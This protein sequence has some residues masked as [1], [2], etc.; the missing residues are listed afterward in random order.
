MRRRSERGKDKKGERH[1]RTFDDCEACVDA[2]LER[3]GKRIVAGTPLG[4]G[5]PNALVNALYRR[6]KADPSIQL[7]LLTAL[8]LNPPQG[9]SEL[10]ERYLAPVRERVWPGYPRLE[11]ADDRAAGKLPAN[12]RVI[13]FYMQSGA[14]LHNASAQQNYI[15]S[16]YSH[17]ARD[18]VSRGVNLLLQAVALREEGGRRRLSLSSNPDTS[19]PI[20]E[21][22]RSVDRPWLACGQVNRQ[23]PWMGNHAEVGE[24]FFQFLLD[25]PALDHAPFAVPHEPVGLTDWAIGCRAS[26]LVRDGGTLQVGIGALGDA[27]CHALRLRQKDNP[28]YAAV[29]DALGADPAAERLGGR[30]GFERGLHVASELIS[31]PLFC[32]FEDG[33]VRRAVCSESGDGMRELPDIVLQGAFFV[34]P[35]DFYRRLRELPEERRALIDMTSVNVVN[36]IYRRYAPECAE[37]RHPRFI[38]ITMKVTLLGAAASDQV[39]DGQVVSGVG[40]QFDF[41]SMAH[42]M[43]EGRSVL[44]LRA[45]RG[46]GKKLESNIVWQFPHATVPRHMRDVHVTEYGVADLRGKTDSECIAALLAIADSRFQQALLEQAQ[47][48]GKMPADYRIPEAQRNNLP[49]RIAGALAPHLKS[50]RLPALPFGCD[51]NEAD[52]ALMARLNKLKATDSGWGGKLRLLRA[53]AAPAAADAPEV[54]AALQH[55]KLAQPATARERELARLVRAAFVL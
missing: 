32:L 50:G 33:I 44:L 11:F 47:R 55:L 24:D 4:I 10:E 54:A 20:V 37:R 52:R 15:S 43:P 40:G 35:A 49:A 23:L 22:L 45:T 21:M 14:M 16:N 39:A 29:L 8:T 42:Q 51:I 31:N 30:G 38:N 19:L 9:K 48:A 17:A 34:G 13:E 12:V 6:A 53:L 46:A 27:V 5:K 3:L 28:G 2:I 26:A 18:M 25:D 41:V 36:S 1:L 7:E